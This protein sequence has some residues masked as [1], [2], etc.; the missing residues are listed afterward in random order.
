MSHSNCFRALHG[1]ERKMLL[2]TC[3]MAQKQ[4]LCWQCSRKCWKLPSTSQWN[5][6]RGR[7]KQERKGPAAT[8]GPML[9]RLCNCH[10]TVA[11]RAGALPCHWKAATVV[12]LSSW[13]VIGLIRLAMIHMVRLVQQRVTS[14][15]NG[16]RPCHFLIRLATVG[17]M[18][19][20]VEVMY[21]E[22]NDH[23]SKG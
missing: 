11:R 12:A 18:I 1:R 5:A 8:I 23:P 4:V 7:P 17:H 6:C 13:E 9:D 10:Q 16:T 19:R 20:R 3:C 15:D 2:H 22:P 21:Q 14:K